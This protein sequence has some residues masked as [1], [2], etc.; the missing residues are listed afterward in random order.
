MCIRSHFSVYLQPFLK[1]C[2]VVVCCYCV[3]EVGTMYT[4]YRGMF[5]L[6][7]FVE[8]SDLTETER[9][10]EF[11]RLVF[12]EMLRDVERTIECGRI[13]LILAGLERG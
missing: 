13:V 8:R 5:M 1:D 11:G 6:S 10:V 4:Y 7:A 3:C 12:G 9:T 2:T